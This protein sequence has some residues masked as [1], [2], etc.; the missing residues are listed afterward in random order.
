MR[1]IS[2]EPARVAFAGTPAFSVP[3]LEALLAAG[4][5]VP[6][7]LT[8]PDRP[9]GRGRKLRASEIK[10]HAEARG[11][12]V[13]QPARLDDAGVLAGWGTPPDALVVVAYGLKLP[14]W[15][16][17]WPRVGCIN[18]HASLLPRWR[19]AAPIQYAILAGDRETGVSLMRMDAGLDRGAVYAR[20]AMPIGAQA[21]AGTL[22]DD[23][24]RLGAELLVDRLPEILAGRLTPTPQ[25]DADS[26][27]APK[28]SKA[29]AKLDWTQ[30]A[31]IIERRIRAFNPW[32]VAEA[33]LSDGRRL[34]IWEAE[35]LAADS[36]AAPG[37]IVA[38]GARGVDVATGQGL[39]RI[40]RLQPPSAKVMD[41]AAYLAAHDLSGV[42][43][44]G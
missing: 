40:K 33:R 8:Q 18:V 16:L 2:S 3:S 14:D 34:R 9:F 7:V 1:R 13:E 22:H 4:F 10:R 31:A 35:T 27:V 25:R 42:S 28:I 12:R 20:R 38:A 36:D 11:L 43:F 29:D 30:A 23:L 6:L 21:T 26:T 39:L 32:P 41:A 37:S 44:G 5:D 17:G 15:L 19:G 24:A